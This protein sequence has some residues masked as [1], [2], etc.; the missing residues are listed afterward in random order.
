MSLQVIA[1][2]NF[3]KNVQKLSDNVNLIFLEKNIKN[4]DSL[5]SKNYYKS[6]PEIIVLIDQ[7]TQ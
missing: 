2:V 6:H 7:C 4:W 1:V 5:M 3:R